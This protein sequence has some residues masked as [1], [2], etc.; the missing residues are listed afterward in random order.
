ML[1]LWRLLNT[2]PPSLNLVANLV[3][4]V[5]AGLPI[6][7]PEIGVKQNRVN[8]L[9]R[10]CDTGSEVVRNRVCVVLHRTML[11]KSIVDPRFSN[12]KA[13][14]DIKEE[15][16]YSYV[17]FEKVWKFELNG[18]QIDG[19]YTYLAQRLII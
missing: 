16:D 10:K 3:A 11:A 5:V 13:S 18:F 14:I 6:E 15:G 2:A 9:G 1:P 17:P 19:L 4:F 8:Y 12:D 7:F